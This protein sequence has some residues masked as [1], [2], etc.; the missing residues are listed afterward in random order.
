MSRL[1]KLNKESELN[2]FQLYDNVQNIVVDQIDQ[3]IKEKLGQDALN[4]ENPKTDKIYNTLDIYLKQL[5]TLLTNLKT[6]VNNEL[7]N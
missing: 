3:A 7:L 1:A 4:S 5:E 2:S 6:E